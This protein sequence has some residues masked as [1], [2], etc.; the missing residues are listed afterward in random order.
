MMMWFLISSALASPPMS[1]WAPGLI[2]VIPDPVVLEL[3]LERYDVP[4][5][6]AT[7]IY[8][9]AGWSG[10]VFS[11][12]VRKAGIGWT[13]ID[14]QP[15]VRTTDTLA[16][17]RKPSCTVILDENVDIAGRHLSMLWDAWPIRDVAP[18]E[19]A[20]PQALLAG[21]DEKIYAVTF[22]RPGETVQRVTVTDDRDESTS[23]RLEL[24]RGDKM[25]SISGAETGTTVC[26][27]P[28]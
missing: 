26:Y 16:S 10:D 24:T 23:E 4:L 14:G 3:A 19:D 28:K 8:G 2:D 17:N 9:M 21:D 25:L 18:A 11:K 20:G 7:V 15:I 5:D 1:D 13:S 22:L 27:R 6:S 12:P